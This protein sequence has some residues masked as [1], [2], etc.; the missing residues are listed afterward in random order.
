MFLSL[1][2]F[3]LLQSNPCS[4]PIIFMRDVEACHIISLLE[5][6]YAGQV[7]VAQ[8]NLSTFLKTAESLKIRGLTDTTESF[9]N[10]DIDNTSAKSE[11]LQ[12]ST[13]NVSSSQDVLEVQ[14]ASSPPSKKTK[15][16]TD[17]SKKIECNEKR[18]INVNGNSKELLNHT[19]QPK[20]ELPEYLSDIDEGDNEVNHELTSLPAAGDL[21]KLPGEIFLSL[22]I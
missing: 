14:T 12:L 4:H 15:I 7:N 2:E 20:D 10:Q 21:I 19:W 8:A 9:F 17:N 6:M 5:F 18:E 3:I 11:K 13:N 22:L 1:L 16:E